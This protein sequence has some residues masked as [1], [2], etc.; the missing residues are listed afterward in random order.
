MTTTRRKTV[1]QA[2]KETEGK[3]GAPIAIKGFVRYALGE[4]IEKATGDFA[5]DGLPRQGLT[6][7]LGPLYLDRVRRAD[8]AIRAAARIA[9]RGG[10]TN[11]PRPLFKRVVV[12]L[13]G[14]ALMGAGQ[15]WPGRADS[16]AHRP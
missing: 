3:V 10:M 12:K 8:S 1:A 11:A 13:S 6:R 4:G 15:A 7:P 14:E 2:V 16:G 5:A 9:R